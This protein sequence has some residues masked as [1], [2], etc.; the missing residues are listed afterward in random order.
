MTKSLIHPRKPP[1][2]RQ[3][4]LPFP[5]AE[6]TRPSLPTPLLTLTPQQVWTTLPR[7]ARTHV[8]NVVLHVIQEV[9]NESRRA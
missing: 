5:V 3:L 6:L 2:T 9:C 8:H 1:T 7:A 4:P